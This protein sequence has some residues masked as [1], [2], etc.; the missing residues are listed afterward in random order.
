MAVTPAGMLSA[1]LGT[2]RTLLSELAAVQT[3]MGV[4][5]AAAALLRIHVSQFNE[6]AG[7][8]GTPAWKTAAEALR[9]RI[10][11]GNVSFDAE[12]TDQSGYFAKDGELF[13]DFQEIA[14]NDNGV[15]T[16]SNT[17]SD[18]DAIFSLMNSV[19]AIMA[20]YE[21]T[22]AAGGSFHAGGYSLGKQ[23]GRS[24]SEDVTAG[25]LDV[26][27]MDFTLRRRDMK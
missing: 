23:A 22:V 2:L 15:Q 4:A 3:W 25:N 11:I 17:V 6:P 19:G 5:N 18:T 7:N 21:S 12:D 8:A 26:V 27:D 24:K 10:V 16:S 14:Q 13:I 1:P 9:P 20:E